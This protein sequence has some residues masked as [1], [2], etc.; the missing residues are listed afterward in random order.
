MLEMLRRVYLDEK[1]IFLFEGPKLGLAI[2][3]HTLQ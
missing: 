2:V 1:A 3:L